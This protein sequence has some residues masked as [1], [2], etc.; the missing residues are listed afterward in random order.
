LC[1]KTVDNKIHHSGERDDDS[2]KS[3]WLDEV[4]RTE[5]TEDISNADHFTLE[6]DLDYDDHS[7][8]LKYRNID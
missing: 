5:N 3:E 2:P 7:P 6:N 8:K 4:L 1:T